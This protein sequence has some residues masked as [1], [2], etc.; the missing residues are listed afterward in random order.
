MTA[1][2]ANTMWQTHFPAIT[3]YYQIWISQC[4]MGTSTITPA[5]GVLSFWL[6]CHN[7][8]P[9]PFI[10]QNLV[11]CCLLSLITIT[12]AQRGRQ[13]EI[14][15]GCIQAVKVLHEITRYYPGERLQKISHFLLISGAISP[16]LWLQDRCIVSDLKLRTL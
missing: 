10:W 9:V 8:T 16:L 7:I 1:I 6:R 12:P 4:I 11:W 5:R 15:R 3:A 13:G 2:G 14:I